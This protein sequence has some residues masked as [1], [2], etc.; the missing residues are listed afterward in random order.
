MNTG[1]QHAEGP[2][3][4]CGL[5]WTDALPLHR[6]LCP[7]H[8]GFVQLPVPVFNPLLFSEMFSVRMN[9]LIVLCMLF[10]VHFVRLSN[11]ANVR[12]FVLT[13]TVKLYLQLMVS[14]LK[15][16]V[17]VCSHC[18]CCGACAL[19]VIDSELQRLLVAFSSTR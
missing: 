5:N 12:V 7:G 15:H 6:Y 2:C 4:T 1:P 16:A 8:F 18:S 13:F 11:C 19:Y 3:V 9:I 14:K 10:S 17:V